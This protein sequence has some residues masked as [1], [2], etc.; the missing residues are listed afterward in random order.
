MSKKLSLS[1]D[2]VIPILD[3]YEEEWN[4]CPYKDLYVNDHRSIVYQSPTL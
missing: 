3:I 4:I 2:S 1:Y